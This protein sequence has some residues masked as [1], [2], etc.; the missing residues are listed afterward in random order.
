MDKT[1]K[2]HWGAAM[3]ITA[4]VP[5]A[6]LTTRAGNLDIP[7]HDPAVLAVASTSKSTSVTNARG[8]I[9]AIGPDERTLLNQQTALSVALAEQAAGGC[10]SYT[11]SRGEK[12]SG[13]K[14]P[15]RY[16]LLGAIG[17]AILGSYGG[18]A[19]AAAGGAIGAF[20]FYGIGSSTYPK[21]GDAP[22][23]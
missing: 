4:L 22:S 6:P 3:L 21:D 14:S 12:D 13:C 15:F 2:L 5:L 8:N 17:G 19:G 1:L 10:A 7:A 20:I 18:V 23:R 11:N 9:R 16:S